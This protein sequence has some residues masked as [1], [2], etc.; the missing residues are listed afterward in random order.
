MQ[1]FTT[2]Y[3]SVDI[4]RTMSFGGVYLIVIKKAGNNYD[5]DISSL[6]SQNRGIETQMVAL[7]KAEMG[8]ENE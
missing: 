7:K 5:M 4:S 1:S 2:S 6:S 8:K 3:F